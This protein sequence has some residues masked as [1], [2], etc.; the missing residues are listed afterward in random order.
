MRVMRLVT[1]QGGRAVQGSRR[2]GRSRTWS[3]VGW[4][5]WEW[6]PERSL[7]EVQLVSVVYSEPEKEE[8]LKLKHSLYNAVCSE[9]IPA[10]YLIQVVSVVFNG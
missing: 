2:V 9:H 6:P 7:V 4:K 8:N 3:G 10:T 1:V 5:G